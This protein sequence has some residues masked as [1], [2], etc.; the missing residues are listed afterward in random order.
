VRT[1]PPEHGEP[2]WEEGPDWPAVVVVAAVGM[3]GAALAVAT[4]LRELGAE[5]PQATVVAGAV[6]L[7]VACLAASLLA[8]AESLH[9]ERIEVRDGALDV[10][11]RG[12][13]GSARW[14][15]PLS[16]YEGLVVID[17]QRRL[18]VRN[19]DRPPTGRRGPVTEF[20]VVLR[21]G[22]DRARDVELFRAQPSLETLRAMHAMNVSRA[23]SG[24]AGAR[25]VACED[26]A[27]G[28][29]DAVCRLARTLRV[30]VLIVAGEGQAARAVDPEALDPWMEEPGD[31]GGG[32]DT[33]SA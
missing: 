25:A 6:L 2:R 11:Q 10:V 9:R 3:V 28:Y 19:Q 7:A 5:A 26:R 16:S 27:R 13:A 12:L 15:E 17:R 24:E 31:G 1:L 33:L 21:H 4:L 14:R 32:G 23:G 30:K 18:F 22:A 29:R 8:I 20:V